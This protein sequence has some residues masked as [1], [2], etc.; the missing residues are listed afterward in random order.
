MSN[1]LVYQKGYL[2]HFGQDALT[3][4]ADDLIDAL[5]EGYRWATAEEAANWT[6]HR[7]RMVQVVKGGT[8]D[9]PWTDLAI[10]VD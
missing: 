8:P 5:P 10:K 1:T 6:E 9:E 2:D 3:L 4:T 7:E